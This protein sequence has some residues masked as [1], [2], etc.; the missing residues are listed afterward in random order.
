[1]GFLLGKL[2]QNTALSCPNSLHF[3]PKITVKICAEVLCYNLGLFIPLH[4]FPRFILYTFF[5]IFAHLGVGF[6]GFGSWIWFLGFSVDG[7]W[8]LRCRTF[9]VFLGLGSLY[10]HRRIILGKNLAPTSPSTDQAI[11]T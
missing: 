2:R 7:V 8:G 5:L 10:K 9:W 3:S 4:I 6:S 11:N 1:M